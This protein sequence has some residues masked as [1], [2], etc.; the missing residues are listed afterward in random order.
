M[1]RLVISEIL[2][3]FVNTLTGDDKYSL[4]T[5]ESFWQTIQVQLSKKLPTFSHF[6]ISFL[7]STS[8]YQS[9][10]KKMTLTSCV[11]QKRRRG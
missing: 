5:S 8:N 6:F 1:S 11:F 2:G 3:L 7:K 10:Q 9:F 4:R